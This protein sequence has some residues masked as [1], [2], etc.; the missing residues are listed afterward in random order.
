M[1]LVQ[2]MLV[3]IMCKFLNIFYDHRKLSSFD[4]GKAIFLGTQEVGQMDIAL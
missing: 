2:F 3:S 1:V 4:G